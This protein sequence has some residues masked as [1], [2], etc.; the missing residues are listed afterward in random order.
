MTEIDPEVRANIRGYLFDSIS[1]LSD[2]LYQEATW[3]L[4]DNPHFTFVEFAE[5]FFDTLPDGADDAFDRG[6]ISA[7]ERDA[8]RPLWA[9][10]DGYEAPGEDNYDVFSMLADPK[11]H[12]VVQVAEKC[13]EDL[14]LLVGTEDASRLSHESNCDLPPNNKGD[15]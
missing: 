4:I 5:C 14:L 6:L 2:L 13:R 9:A 7:S 1:E 10:L 12:E 3:G 11:W 8:I 15:A